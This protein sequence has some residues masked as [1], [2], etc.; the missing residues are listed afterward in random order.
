MRHKKGQE[1]SNHNSHL[2]VAKQSPR[3][4]NLTIEKENNGKALCSKVLMPLHSNS[5]LSKATR[6]NINTRHTSCSQI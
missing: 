5:N 4:R 1:D 2:P 3:T 6:G